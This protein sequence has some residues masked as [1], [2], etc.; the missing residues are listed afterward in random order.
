M[1]VIYEQIVKVKVSLHYKK[2][3]SEI[4]IK[5]RIKLMMQ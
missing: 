5:K 2:H 4:G 3:W 1:Y